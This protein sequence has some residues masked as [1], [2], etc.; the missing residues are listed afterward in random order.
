MVTVFPCF[1]HHRTCS[2][3]LECFISR[4][5]L[6]HLPALR[7]VNLTADLRY[8]PTILQPLMHA[9]HLE[10]LTIKASPGMLSD[11]DQYTLAYSIWALAHVA[12]RLRVT[13]LSFW[14][15]D[16]NPNSLYL[17]EDV[18]MRGDL[19]D[20]MRQI[21]VAKL[22]GLNGL[23]SGRLRFLRINRDFITMDAIS[24]VEF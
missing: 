8:L 3:Q 14:D 21:P 13:F 9:K 16:Y 20:S 2:S 7:T 23:D 19:L 4:G 11:C 5:G 6:Y 12:V 22:W 24:I 10:E 15:N 1:A 17:S 18:F